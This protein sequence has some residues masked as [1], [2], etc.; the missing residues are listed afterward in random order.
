MRNQLITLLAFLALPTILFA[1]TV[2]SDTTFRYK[3]KVIKVEDQ[4]DQM[5]V[6]VYET[7]NGKDTVACKQIF[8]GIYSD[9]K[10]YETWSVIEE[11][12]IQ[13]P[14]LGKPK[15]K[16]HNSKCH[17]D[18]HYAGVGIG[19]MNVTDDG[20]PFNTVSTDRFA[21]KAEET[22]EWFINLIEHS[23]SLYRNRLAL[24]T[25]LGINWRTYRMDQNTMLREVNGK[26][27]MEPFDLADNYEYS[28]LKVTRITMPLLLEWQPG[29]LRKSFLSGGVEAGL[30]TYS[31]FKVK[32][33]NS[34]GDVVKKVT[35]RGLNTT[36]LSFDL[37]LMAGIDNI[38]I[39]AKQSLTGVFQKDK[40]PDV[41]PVSIGV[42]LNF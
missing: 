22:T 24:V 33:K 29:F 1:E 17:M 19:Y 25:G 14:G 39:F 30:K 11:I 8:E 16:S 32:Y 23:Y 38:S 7:R 12:G 40:G 26:T 34:T 9:G 31:T 21:L 2:A 36:P 13:L 5:K 27:E 15:N 20:N 3:N 4:P 37:M 18:P 35:D 41:K 28:R 10:S 42:V 6:K